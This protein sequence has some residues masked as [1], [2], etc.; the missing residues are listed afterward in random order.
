MLQEHSSVSSLAHFSPVRALKLPAK[1]QGIFD[2]QGSILYSYRSLTLQQA[3]G[4]ALAPGFIKPVGVLPEGA[5][6]FSV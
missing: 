4:N 3:I 1:L 5:T 2:P 6:L